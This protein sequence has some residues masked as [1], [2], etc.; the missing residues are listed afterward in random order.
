MTEEDGTHQHQSH[1]HRLPLV[2]LFLIHIDDGLETVNASYYN[3]MM[4]DEHISSE[5]IP[6]LCSNVEDP[7]GSDIFTISQTVRFKYVKQGNAGNA[8]KVRTPD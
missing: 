4:T 2:P 6:H 1:R 3:L 8:P 5:Y 7:P